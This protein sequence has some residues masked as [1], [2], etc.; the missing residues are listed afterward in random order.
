MSKIPLELRENELDTLKKMEHQY[1]V[2]FQEYKRTFNIYID[3]L[4]GKQDV[5]AYKGSNIKYNNEYYRIN[6]H[7]Y[8]RKYEDWE[9]RDNTCKGDAVELEGEQASQFQKLL[10]NDII[11]KG[12]RR[13]I[14]EPCDLEGNNIELKEEI[15]KQI[16]IG[17]SS[18]YMKTVLLPE[19]DLTVT[20]KPVNPQ[21]PGWS[22]VFKTKVQKIPFS[23]DMLFVERTDAKDGW[24]QNLI[25]EGRKSKKE[26]KEYTINVGTSEN[27]SKMVVL[28]ETNMTVVSSP[29]QK[30]NMTFKTN[31]FNN[32]LIVTRTDKKFGWTESIQLKG[33]KKQKY[34]KMGYL[35]QSGELDMYPN[36]EIAIQHAMKNGCPKNTV[37]LSPSVFNT[38]TKSSTTLN[39]ESNCSHFKLNTIRN[40]LDD[41]QKE[42]LT[43]S[44][45]IEKY[46]Q[47]SG[48]TKPNF[49]SNIHNLNDK[50]KTITDLRNKIE[51][52]L[53]YVGNSKVILENESLSLNNENNKLWMLLGFSILSGGLIFKLTR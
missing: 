48:R 24:G 20:G 26:S 14:G 41:L 46:I 37:E 18:F 8:M 38:F 42:L 35:T 1:K 21:N 53:K 45:K 32:Q 22:D 17:S 16:P 7:G 9:K 11:L 5:D 40:K 3:S 2:L 4:K 12:Y 52:D 23:K 34:S 29:L 27:N 47:T 36:D 39:F 28:P 51:S 13:A 19:N 6:N 30:T 33:Y 49:H 25:L 10:D 43:L 31:V 44:K 50:M 15:V